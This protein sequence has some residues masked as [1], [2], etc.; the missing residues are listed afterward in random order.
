[1]SCVYLLLKSTSSIQLV[2][3]D[4]YHIQVCGQSGV[5]NMACGPVG[6]ADLVSADLV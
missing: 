1:M 4:V 6:M 2:I 5:V 3:N